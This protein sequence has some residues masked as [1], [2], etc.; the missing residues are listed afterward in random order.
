VAVRKTIT[1]GL[2]QNGWVEVMAGLK[3]DERIVADGTNR[4]RPG[5]PVQI[6]GAGPRRGA[7]GTPP[8]RAPQA[9]PKAAPQNGQKPAAA[10]DE[11]MT[12]FR[13]ADANGDG[14]VS[15]AEWTTLGRQPRLF[16]RLDTDGNGLLSR[17]EMQAITTARNAG[18]PNS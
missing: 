16:T 15:E 9:A 6:A 1:A 3:P 5:D 4:V 12:T 2:R 11:P 8:G 17:S 7:N 10:P 14:S 18:R 13:S